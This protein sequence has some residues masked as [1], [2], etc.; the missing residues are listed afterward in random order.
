MS[1]HNITILDLPTSYWH[2]L[3]SY[4]SER[5]IK[6]PP[7]IRLVIL[8]GEKLD[9]E[10][11][12]LWQ[13]SV[14]NYPRLV[15]TYGCTEGT[16]VTTKYDIPEVNWNKAENINIPIGRPIYNCNVYILDQDNLLVPYLIPGEIC[17]G[18]EGIAKEYL[19]NP[20]LTTKKFICN[21]Y[22]N[23][24]SRLYKTGDVGRWLPDGNIELLGRIDHQVKIRNF[25]IEIGEIESVL[26]KYP[27]VKEQIVIINKDQA[28]DTER[29]IAYIVYDKKLENNYDECEVK[30][31]IH[32]NTLLP[33]YMIPSL[34]IFL[35]SMPLNQNGKIDRK[36]LPQPNIDL[37]VS[38]KYIAPKNRTEEILLNIWRLVLKV[39]K[40]S[41]NNNFFS[42]GGH[43]LLSIH[44]L[45]E[46]NENFN[47]NLAVSWIFQYPTIEKQATYLL[48][49][50]DQIYNPICTFNS[51]GICPPLFFIHPGGVSTEIYSGL[52]EKLDKSI[53]FFGVES[54]NIYSNGNYIDSL[55]NLVDYYIKE[56]KKIKPSGP[57]CLG[58]WSFG[59][60]VAY[61]MARQLVLRG[62]R[63]ISVYLIDTSVFSNVE[64]EIN[65][66]LG[67]II[68]RIEV[69]MHPFPLH[70]QYH[71][72]I[73]KVNELENEMYN[74]YSYPTY[75]GKLFLFNAVLP[76]KLSFKI[77]DDEEKI[78]NHY[79]KNFTK[80]KYKGWGEI[81]PNLK[82]I[83]I[84][85]DHFSI[86]NKNNL[87]KIA[88]VIK[89]D[90]NENN[91][92]KVDNK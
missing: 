33:E 26:S 30:L 13:Q 56:I 66:Q 88:N 40:I 36:A 61:E 4:I 68:T 82:E 79:L 3:V 46:I 71:K 1:I 53:P 43:S 49:N 16:V 83:K 86:M 10:K 14:G 45:S 48:E 20:E 23:N 64:K 22:N 60:I 29:I 87:K 42:V 85:A 67:D 28:T 63:V 15:N 50:I 91:L 39:G 8:G 24:N 47:K 31:R 6:P 90:M 7:S 81:V 21:P 74:K 69:A 18:G 41:I 19:N 32:L 34:F 27:L 77:N 65:K 78:Y 84:K 12:K 25:R 62:E 58:G 73:S 11:L 52:A 51:E 72:K 2:Q 44:L 5:T 76:K 17:I 92:K 80:K 57:Y 59:G 54:Y 35:D 70:K 9:V 38:D 89:A 37:I 55:E 75:D